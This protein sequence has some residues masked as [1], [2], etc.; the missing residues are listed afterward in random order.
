MNNM[1]IIENNVQIESKMQLKNMSAMDTQ[2][3][4]VCAEWAEKKR[5]NIPDRVETP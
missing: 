4:L 2:R 5:K 1:Q 3:K